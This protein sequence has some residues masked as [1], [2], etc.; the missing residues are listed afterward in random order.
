MTYHALF[1]SVVAGSSGTSSTVYI[2]FGMDVLINLLFTLRIIYFKK[3]GNTKA[4]VAT[5]QILLLTE[6]VEV[7]A[8]IIYSV[9]FILAYYGPNAEVLGNIKNSYYHYHAVDDIWLAFKNLCLLMIIDLVSINVTIGIIYR[10]VGINCFKVIHAY[11]LHLI[12]FIYTYIFPF[13]FPGV[14]AHPEGVW[15]CPWFAASIYHHASLLWDCYWM[16][17]GL[18]L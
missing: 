14:F 5:I 3:C 9:C 16:C 15:G 17:S 8:P 2:L 11:C 10:F 6:T 1:L 13:Q 12:L 4:I 18:Q 7:T